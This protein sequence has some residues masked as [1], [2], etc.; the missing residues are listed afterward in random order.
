VNGRCP[1]CK[2]VRNVRVRR[3]DKI[4]NY[5]C[6][7]CRVPLQGVAAGRGRGRYLCPIDAGVVTLGR[8]GVEL[9]RPMRLVWRLG[10]FGRHY[11]DE[12]GQFDSERLERVAGRVLGPCCVVSQYFAPD[13]DLPASWDS[14]AGLYLVDADDPGDAATWIVNEP[15]VYR[16]CAA[17][18]SRIPDLPE[19]HVL[20]EWTPRQTSVWRGRGRYKRH[21][22]DIDPGPTRLAASPAPAATRARRRGTDQHRLVTAAMLIVG[23]A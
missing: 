3:G 7:T 13:R 5:Y 6:P 4:S 23:L 15:L 21:T 8:T 16:T 12:P 19:R 10:E 22:A 14:R 17:C 11:L 20:T 18:G 2:D 1:Q 9:D